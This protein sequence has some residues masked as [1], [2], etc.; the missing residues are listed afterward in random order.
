MVFYCADR[1]FRREGVGALQYHFLT[2]HTQNGVVILTFTEPLLN[3]DA[4][5]EAIS[6]INAGESR[7]VILNCQAVRFLAG[8]SLSRLLKLIRNLTDKDGRL[9]VCNVAPDFAEVLR[10]TRLNRILKIRPNVE[11]AFACIE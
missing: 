11:S 1:H 4:V 3:A 5:E 9:V 7:K 10:V 8:D 2:Q 6:V